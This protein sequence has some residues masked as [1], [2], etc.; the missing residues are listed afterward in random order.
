MGLVP[1]SELT[2]ERSRFSGALTVFTLLFVLLMGRF[3]YLQILHGDEFREKA[4]V[5]F[6]Y[7]ERVPARRGVIRDRNGKVVAEN[8]P[9]FALTILPHALE[10]ADVRKKTLDKLGQ[11]L[12]LTDQER[13]EI[14]TTI[15]DKLK[16]SQ[17]WQPFVVRNELVSEMC[18]YD[19]EKLDL[20]A[21]HDNHRHKHKKKRSDAGH[22]F[23]GTCGL[24]HVGLDKSATRC[25]H[26]RGR[27]TWQSSEK[28]HASC[29]K[30]RRSYVTSP[31]CPH[32]GALLSSISHNLSCSVCKR[33][34][35]NEVAV[36]K[37]HKHE[38]P[39]VDIKTTFLRRYPSRYLAAHVTG[40]MNLVNVKDRERAKGIYGLRDRIGRAG[41]EAALEPVLRGKP[42][43]AEF[44]K[45]TGQDVLGG[46]SSS[47][48]GHDVWLTIDSKLQNEV[49][50]AIRYFRSAAAVVLDPRTGEILASYSTPGYD[51]NAWSRRL[52]K[53]RWERIKANPYYPMV[54]KALTSYA[55]GSVYKIVTALAILNEGI[56][57]PETTINCPGRYHYGGR[58]FRCHNRRGHG[59]MDLVDALKY[60]CDVYFYRA[61]EE[62]GMD[63]LAEYGHA[64]GYGEPTGIEV[65]EDKGRVPTKKW[66]NDHTRL[67]FRPGLTLST[68]I[69]QGA[70]TASP[71]QVA[72]S[73]AALANGGKV[74]ESRLI[75]QFTDEQ[76][77]VVQR[78]LPIE[79]GK[80]PGTPEQLALIREGLVRVVNDR[81][82][83]GRRVALDMMVVAGKTGTAEAAQSRPGAEEDLKRWLLE[84]H[85]WFAGYAPAD[86][87]QVVVVAFLEHGGSGGKNAGPVVKR[88][89]ESWVRLGFYRGSP[90]P[91][92]PTPTRP[93]RRRGR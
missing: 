27:L 1:E 2:V 93:A 30:C 6:T 24:T 57:P 12:G 20:L 78:F 84:D 91:P 22:L 35:S 72:R 14:E 53:E 38:L 37:A 73:F 90:P 63:R 44:F 75:K 41:V 19:G 52:S 32:D 88:I 87:P 69:G 28:H 33:H 51:P 50:Q 60:S 61:G 77:E 36:I 47:D 64:Y 16:A 58:D 46:F 66:H 29:S 56:W 9:R 83:T 13:E 65:R 49:R 40:Y 45:G 4:R 42:G 43:E 25:P 80:L 48:P 23:C 11:L 82:G 70:L 26:D 86:D 34:F 85:A 21:G 68:A 17:G 39:G 54:N 89:L 7:K 3:F 92:D 76:G 79:V 74:L 31:V 55:P 10:K 15:A 81:D 71:L 5:S 8:A 62:L 18:P 59:D 67:G